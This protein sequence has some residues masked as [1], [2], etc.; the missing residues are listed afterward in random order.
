MKTH[1]NPHEN[2]PGH[3][4]RSTEVGPASL[5]PRKALC[6]NQ[7]QWKA[8][9]LV[10]RRHAGTMQRTRLELSCGKC[11]EKLDTYIGSMMVVGEKQSEHG[12]PGTL[13]FALQAVD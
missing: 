11:E 12:N 4:P 9:Q 5:V 10:C 8:C 2:V 6:G 3:E 13:G 1:E 7:R